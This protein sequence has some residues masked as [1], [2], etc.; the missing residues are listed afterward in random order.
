[1]AIFNMI[2]TSVTMLRGTRSWVNDDPFG[3]TACKLLLFSQ[4]SSVAC[5]IITLT[6]L[7]FER[8]FAVVYPLWKIV[9][10]EKTRWIIAVI[11][12]A[13]F[14]STSP[15][16]YAAKVQL[17]QGVPYCIEDWAPAF[18]P[19]RARGIYTIVT[20]VL[21]Y[22]LPLLVIAVLY[23]IV[24]A[25]VWRRHIAGNATPANIRL[26]NKSKKNVLKMLIIVVLAFALCW[27][28]IHLNMFLQDFSD[29]FSCGIPLGL[30][31][32]GFLLGHANTAINWCIYV[33]F[34]QDFRRGFKD[35]V[36][37]LFWK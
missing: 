36:S 15:I 17:F 8:Y 34:S 2:P 16:L 26:F 19:N 29:I 12:I 24:I 33:I 10:V 20:F 11:W 14:S 28:L 4:G 5:S 9:T 13:S 25:K 27:F 21:L 7:A 6:A 18:D 3:Q 22:A 37:P 32:T 1:M 30:Q 23:S 35:F 31:T